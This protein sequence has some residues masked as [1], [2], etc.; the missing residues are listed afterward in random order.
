MQYFRNR[1]RSYV[2]W[3]TML[4]QEYYL[5][6]LYSKLVQP[7]AKRIKSDYGSADTVTDVAFAN[8]D[9][10]IV[11]VVANQTNAL[12]EIALEGNQAWAAIDPKTAVALVWRPGAGTST[13]P[14]TAPPSM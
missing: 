11:V 2:S 9:G 12:Q 8:R 7:G 10:T 14:P 3:V 13:A 5:F 4:D 1:A 6:G